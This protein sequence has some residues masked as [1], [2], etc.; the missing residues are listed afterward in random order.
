M[1][2]WW[3][4]LKI[5][6]KVVATKYFFCTVLQVTYSKYIGTFY[7]FSIKIS[8][9]QKKTPKSQQWVLPQHSHCILST[10]VMC[11]LYTDWLCILYILCNS[12]REAQAVLL[13]KTLSQRGRGDRMAALLLKHIEKER[14]KLHSILPNSNSSSSSSSSSVKTSVRSFHTQKGQYTVHI[15]AP[16]GQFVKNICLILLWY[17]R[18]TKPNI[19]MKISG[20]QDRRSDTEQVRINSR[21]TQLWYT[22]SRTLVLFIYPIKV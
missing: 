14:K 9:M 16:K 13:R 10:A 12:L 1:K 5:Q 6:A 21:S 18:T 3:P 4:H 8:R 19:R 17:W 22:W 20:L 11:V 15:T 2:W 7:T